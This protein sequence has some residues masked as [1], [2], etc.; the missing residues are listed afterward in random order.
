MPEFRRTMKIGKKNFEIIS[1]KSLEENGYEIKTLPISLRILLENLLRRLDNKVVKE[2]HIRA[3][4]ERKK[5]EIPFFPERIVLQDYTGIPVVLDLVA[6][7]N[8]VI[9][10]GYDG[11]RINPVVPVDLVIDHSVQV[12]RFGTVY[13]LRENMELEFKRNE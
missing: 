1:L 12:D 11:K 7:R 5:V 9:R 13:S 4:V 2:E 6:M 8:A 3:I 10:M